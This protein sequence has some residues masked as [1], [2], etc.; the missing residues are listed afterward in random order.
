[1]KRFDEKK[2]ILEQY[3]QMINS[4]DKLQI[5]SIYLKYIIDNVE[6]DKDLLELDLDLPILNN[7]F[8]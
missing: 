3:Q 8:S 4:F 1:M 5:I 2:H 6:T 7:Q